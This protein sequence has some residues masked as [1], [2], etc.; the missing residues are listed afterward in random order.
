MHTLAYMLQQTPSL[1]NKLSIIDLQNILA[2]GDQACIKSITQHYQTS[3]LFSA[4][5]PTADH[6]TMQHF[7][8]QEQQI[9]ANYLTIMLEKKDDKKISL[10]VNRYAEHFIA[11]MKE[12]SYYLDIQLLGKIYSL[13][14]KPQQK[15]GA[16]RVVLIKDFFKAW[17]YQHTLNWSVMSHHENDLNIF[18]LLAFFN[19]TDLLLAFKNQQQLLF[20][21]NLGPA[22][23]ENY[24]HGITPAWLL[25][26]HGKLDSV[27]RSITSKKRT[28]DLNASPTHSENMAHGITPAWL[29][30]FNQQSDEL[31]DLLVKQRPTS[32]DPNTGPTHPNNIECGITTSYLLAQHNKMTTFSAL[33]HQSRLP[34]NLN[35]APLYQA[36]IRFGTDLIWWLA[37]HG[38]ID[39][40]LTFVNHQPNTLVNLNNK[41]IHYQ[42]PNHNMTTA[43]LIARN[44][45]YD[46]LSRIIAL[47]PMVISL[48][49]APTSPLNLH[50]G[51]TL[52]WWM[53][54]HNRTNELLDIMQQ[55]PN[56]PIN[57]NATASH[58]RYN[59]SGTT[60]AWWLVRHNQI[61]VLQQI[62]AQQPNIVIDINACSR[63]PGSHLCGI[64]IAYFLA[65][66]GHFDLLRTLAQQPNMVVDLGAKP[67]NPRNIN[68]YGKTLSDLL[69][70]TNQLQLLEELTPPETPPFF[71][72]QQPYN[73]KRSAEPLEDREPELAPN[74]K[75]SRLN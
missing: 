35:A 30:A 66:Y 47:Q 5:S 25:S 49:T 9:F 57:L 36:N 44:G 26:Y 8:Y 31:Y 38:N 72:E 37:F 13:I 59:F 28:I 24:W 3:W 12:T 16:R 21:L 55:Q 1:I 22:C 20:D 58:P 7:S 42:N 70:E 74:T 71:L 64:T 46:A 51:T 32:I 17:D 2:T 40:L 11:W 48:N 15:R 53:T 62:M 67:L 61:E 33:A 6:R 50:A 63:Q 23:I 60:P 34:I 14:N 68:Y 52:V 43:W 39:T 75:K 45:R 19:Q 65:A 54:Y 69:R 73:K 10:W 41:P 4:L 56:T 18:F 29:L 27:L